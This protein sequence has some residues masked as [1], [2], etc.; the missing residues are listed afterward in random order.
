M[1]E[2]KE[3]IQSVRLDI[4]K[5]NGCLILKELPLEKTD[6][7]FKIRVNKW[8]HNFFRKQKIKLIKYYLHKR[9]KCTCQC[10]IVPGFYHCWDG[11][12]CDKESMNWR[13][14]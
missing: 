4:T 2:I 6:S 3:M 10:H 1:I 9:N 13:K 11:G 14:L 8:Y 12:C 7:I 5:S